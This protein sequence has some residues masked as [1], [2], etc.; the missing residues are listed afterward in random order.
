MHFK[1]EKNWNSK[2][3]LTELIVK[4]REKQTCEL[5]PMVFVCLEFVCMDACFVFIFAIK[6]SCTVNVFIHLLML[7]NK[8]KL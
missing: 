8:P 7:I 2:Q 6:D 5:L 3:E 4:E 1:E